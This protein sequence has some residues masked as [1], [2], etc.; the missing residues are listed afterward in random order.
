MTQST[1]Y[2]WTPVCGLEDIA[3]NTGVC[4]LVKGK[5]VAI[6]RQAHTDKLFAIGNFDPVGKANVLSRGLLAQLG[7]ATTVASPLY[8]QHYC[9]TSGTCLEN[10]ELSVPVYPVRL[11]EGQVEVAAP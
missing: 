10:A 11:S 6:F 2:H 7:E 9:L 3:P 4:A 8:K 5:Q 1:V